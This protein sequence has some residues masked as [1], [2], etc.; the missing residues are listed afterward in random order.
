MSGCGK[1]VQRNEKLT[2]DFQANLISSAET[3]W[4][5]S[6]YTIIPDGIK[7][8]QATDRTK[9]PYIVDTGTTMNYLPPSK[10]YLMAKSSRQSK[11]KCLRG[12]SS[13]C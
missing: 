1:Y 2:L 8:G 10:S 7:W 3:S 12:M 11:G 5:Y 13:S 6:F 4:R 9:F